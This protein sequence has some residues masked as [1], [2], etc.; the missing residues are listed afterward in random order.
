M[1]DVHF[2]CP[3]GSCARVDEQRA[4]QSFHL[5][6]PTWSPKYSRPL[7]FLRI[8][9]EAGQLGQDRRL[10]GVGFLAGNI[11]QSTTVQ[12]IGHFNHCD[13]NRWDQT[14]SVP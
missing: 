5:P 14:N 4:V 10:V 6:V 3:A 2:G 7:D 12:Q 11:L 13:N 1:R 8:Q 9:N